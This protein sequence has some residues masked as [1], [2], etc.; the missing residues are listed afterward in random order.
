MYKIVLRSKAEKFLLNKLEKNTQSKI[1]SKI[2]LL[3][4]D[5]FAPNTNLV[6][7]SGM[8]HGYR[9]R[10]GNIRIVYEISTSPQTIIIWKI[11]WRASAYKP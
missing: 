10:I 7:L 4:Q 3:A 11:D 5:P 6:K 8:E 1:S 2:D 9:L